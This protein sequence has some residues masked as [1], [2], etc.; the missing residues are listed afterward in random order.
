MSYVEEEGPR[1]SKL[2]EKGRRHQKF[3]NLIKQIDPQAIQEL[4]ED[5]ELFE[6]DVIQKI[7]HSRRT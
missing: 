7:Y 1:R 2:D 5:D 6:L 3:R 4:D